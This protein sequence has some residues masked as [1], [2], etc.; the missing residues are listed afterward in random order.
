MN[1]IFGIVVGGFIAFF[2]IQPDRL[3]DVMHWA[4]DK[5]ADREQMEI[6]NND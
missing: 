1:F 4:G 5:I 3:G 6:F 2:C